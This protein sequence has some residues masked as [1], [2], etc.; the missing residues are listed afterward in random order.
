MPARHAQAI[1]EIDTM[2]SVRD[3][4]EPALFNDVLEGMATF[5]E[6]HYKWAHEYINKRT[7][8][9]RG[10]GGTPYMDWLKQLIDETR[11]HK[12]PRN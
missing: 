3:I 5:R 9:P 1:A 10:T 12:L 7:N 6:Q 4:A 2:P 11:A 8:D